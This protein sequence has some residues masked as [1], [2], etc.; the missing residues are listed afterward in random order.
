MIVPFPAG[1]PTD[2]V[3]RLLAQAM[4][5]H[6]KTQVVVENVGGASG[7]VGAARAA[8][9]EPDGYT[10]MMHTGSTAI[11][12]PISRKVAPYNPVEDFAWIALLSEAPFLVAVN[13]TLPITDLR[14]L[15]SH[16]KAQA[17]AQ[18]TFSGTMVANSLRRILLPIRR[19]AK[20]LPPRLFSTTSAFSVFRARLLNF[21]SSPN[22]KSPVMVMTLGFP[23]L[24]STRLNEAA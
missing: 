2:V 7:T 1:G 15:V 14:T 20:R 12:A 5:E 8:R 18:S 21:C 22:S 24:P 19:P 23:S 16:A 11:S 13:P 10:L 3:G 6:L 17:D 9:A 4:G